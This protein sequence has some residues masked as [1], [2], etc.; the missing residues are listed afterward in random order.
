VIRALADDEIDAVGSVLGLARLHQGDGQYL[1]AW[2][3][4]SPLGHV[5][6]T[7]GDPPELQDLEVRDDARRRGVATSL[8]CAA[9]VGCRARGATRVR[10]EVSVGNA[11]ARSLYDSCGY[12]DVGTEPRRVVG[13]IA[14]RTRP[15]EVDDTLLTLEKPLGA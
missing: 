10:C 9:E 7:R 15:I 14:L 5:H 4:T 8:L 13:T 11:A 6:V 12:R 3:G 2:D 1:V